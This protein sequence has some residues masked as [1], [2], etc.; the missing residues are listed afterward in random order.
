MNV[1]YGPGPA[2]VHLPGVLPG[3]LA[4]PKSRKGLGWSAPP[5]GPRCTA[6]LRGPQTLHSHHGVPMSRST[7]PGSAQGPWWEGWPASS[8]AS[9][10]TSRQPY[11]R[12]AALQAAPQPSERRCEGLSGG[13]LP[14]STGQPPPPTRRRSPPLSRSTKQHA[15]LLCPACLMMLGRCACCRATLRPNW[16]R[17]GAR[18]TNNTGVAFPPSRCGAQPID[19]DN[20]A[21]VMG[22]GPHPTSC[23]Q[24][25]I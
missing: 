14:D 5:R 25:K 24:C 8:D 19:P 9:A 13:D 23:C 21:A 15:V 20:A 18:T 11:P 7:A 4:V 12:H 10:H 1:H 16:R 2:S 6:P 22:R 3:L 17:Q